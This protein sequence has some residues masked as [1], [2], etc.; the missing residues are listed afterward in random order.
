[1]SLGEKV[2]KCHKQRLERHSVTG[3]ECLVSF[4]KDF[5]FYPKNNGKNTKGLFCFVLNKNVI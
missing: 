2:G 3:L 1:M 4:I 5:G